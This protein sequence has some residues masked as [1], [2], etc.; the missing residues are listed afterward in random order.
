MRINYLS[1][2]LFVSLS[3][4]YLFAYRPLSVYQ[5]FPVGLS[6]RL[7]VWLSVSLSVCLLIFIIMKFVT[8]GMYR[9]VGIHVSESF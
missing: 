4:P 6:D 5:F 9:C 3:V 7:P 2:C 8:V 1:A